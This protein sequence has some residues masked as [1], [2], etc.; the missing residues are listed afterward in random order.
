MKIWIG[1]DPSYESF[2]AAFP[3]PNQPDR[4]RTCKYD[5]TEAGFTDFYADLPAG[6]AVVIEATGGYS[7][8]LLSWL[9]QKLG[10]VYVAS[11]TQIAGF[12]QMTGARAKNDAQDAIA[13]A[14]FGCQQSP[15]KWQ[16]T[17]ASLATLRQ[18]IA[19]EALLIKQKGS[20]KN[21][22]HAF[23]LAAEPAVEVIEQLKELIEI[24][25][26]K[27]RE[28]EKKIE[29]LVNAYAPQQVKHLKSIPGIGDRT[30]PVLIAMI[31]D[32]NR[33]D[34][35]RQMAA[36]F[37]LTPS[38]FRSGKSI[39]RKP[40]LTKVGPAYLRKL[41]YLG[42]CS[43]IQHNPICKKFYHRLL[44]KGKTKHLAIMAVAHKLVRIAFGVLKRQQPFD[45][46]F[47][48]KT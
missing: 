29:V 45:P 34:S 19:I 27:L 37:G 35:A 8:R 12:R 44:D 31:Q 32:V 11:S 23:S 17:E 40:K 20:Y 38:T 15:S 21:Q 7:A 43:A 39:R 36:F 41:L 33:F 3:I 25:K 6:A 14:R 4:Y 2:D 48:A 46:N 28:V 30:I 9:D 10:E 22:L 18:F 26:E 47:L 5:Q 16:P 42:S 1:I 24:C 13:I